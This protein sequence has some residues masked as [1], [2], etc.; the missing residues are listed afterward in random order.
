[1][2]VRFGHPDEIA[3]LRK[4]SLTTIEGHLAEAI[5]AGELRD[6][7]RLVSMSKRSAIEAAIVELGDG[8]LAPLRFRL[9]EEY[10]F[11]E[12]RYVRSALRRHSPRE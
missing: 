10:T 6:L 12:I 8:L 1:M 7:T 2:V 5:D 9:G 3:G 11:G 4:L